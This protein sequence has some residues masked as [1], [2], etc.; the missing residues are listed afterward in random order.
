MGVACPRRLLQI[1]QVGVGG[2]VDAHHLLCQGATP[3]CML[4]LE[5]AGEGFADLMMIPT[6]VLGTVWREALLG[7]CR[8]ERCWWRGTSTPCTTPTSRQ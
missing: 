8:L 1:Y 3:A 2:P 5:G 7:R 6:P 4:G